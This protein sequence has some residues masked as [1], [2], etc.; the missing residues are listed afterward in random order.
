ML[1]TTLKKAVLILALSSA[2]PL[3]ACSDD[4]ETPTSSTQPGPTVTAPPTTTTPPPDPT[5]PTDNRPVVSLTGVVVNL[6]RGGPGNLDITFRIDD[7]TIVRA[8]GGTPVT[9]GTQTFDTDAVRNGQTV[10][11]Q[12]K[13]DNGFLDA[14]RIDIVTQAPQ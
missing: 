11:V 8:S 4:P 9:S 3:A 12:G 6:T 10:T 2:V 7:F 14:T 1:A 13:R 5:P